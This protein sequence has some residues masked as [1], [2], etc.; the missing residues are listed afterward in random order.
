MARPKNENE[1][2]LREEKAAAEII[3]DAW[4]VTV[5]K[6]QPYVYGVDWMLCRNN[7]SLHSWGEFKRRYCEMEQYDSLMISLGK[8]LR[9]RWN[10]ERSLLPF[11][12]YVKWDNTGVMYKSFPHTSGIGYPMKIGTRADRGQDGDSE[13]MIYIPTSEFSPLKK[14]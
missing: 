14:G 12:I 4:N 13:P 7:L 5:V 1:D 3:E 10:A 9:L 2:D 6:L 8:W 11:A